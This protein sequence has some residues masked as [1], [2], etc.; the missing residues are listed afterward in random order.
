MTLDHVFLLLV[1]LGLTVP[2]YW[3]IS[4]DRFALR[5]TVAIGGSLLVLSLLSPWLPLVPLAYFAVVA[6][7]D[8]ALRRGLPPLILKR[9]AWLVFA[10][11]PFKDLVI[12]AGGGGVGP[13][14]FATATLGL[15]FCALRGFLALRHAADVGRADLGASLL[16]LTFF[17]TYLVGPIAGPG[18]FARSAVAE[19][20]E[21]LNLVVGLCRIGIGCAMFLVLRPAV[22][23]WA[24]PAV[25]AG[26]AAAWAWVLL[27]FIAVYLDFA[28]FSEAAIGAGLLFGVKVPE[29]FHWPLRATSMQDFWRRWHRTLADLV[30]TYLARP[31]TRRTGKPGQAIV[32]SFFLVGLWHEFDANY[33][34]WGIGHGVG[35]ALS[36]KARRS[37]ALGRLPRPLRATGGWALTLGWVAVLSAV[38][39]LPDL[40]EAARLVRILAGL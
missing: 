38:A 23:D 10:P 21:G 7:A 30:G 24:G 6:A 32:V 1:V 34:V 25:P 4:P 14:A 18:Q 8:R 16:S 36:L 37:H 13:A 5:R 2:V 9:L 31:I 29:N 12:A 15:S 20:P 17:P 28:G 3:A 19:R 11:L 39:N 22:T 26:T 40:G 27:R 33:V 35:L